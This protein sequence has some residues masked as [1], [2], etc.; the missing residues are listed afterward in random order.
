MLLAA[1][2]TAQDPD[3]VRTPSTMDRVT[4]YQGQALVERVVT[5]EA[6]QPG[7]MSVVV[8]P[9]PLSADASS[10]QTKVESGSLVV[11]GLELRRRAGAALE[12]GQR[13]ALVARLDGLRAERRTVDVESRGIEAGR[14]ALA[15]MMEGIGA[16]G[17][18]A[19]S[20]A[21]RDDKTVRF[22]MEQARMLDKDRAA[23]EVRYEE[24]DRAIADLEAQLEAG[25]QIREDHQEA[26]LSLF[27]ERPGTAT[28]RLSYLVYGAGWQPTYDVRV[29][30]DLTGVRVGLVA[31][32][33]Q[34]TGEDW[35]DAQLL[36]STSTPSVGLDPP[37]LPR[38][39]MGFV[40]RRAE[41]LRG[42]GYVG[43][44]NAPAAATML[45]S[46]SY[47]GADEE[48][49]E[50]FEAAPTVG[51]QDFGLTA[52][53]VLPERKDLPSNGKAHR[54]TIREMPLQV[55]PERYV[56]PSLSD[57]AYLRAEV[58]LSGETPLLPGVAKV[59]LGPDFLGEASMPL[60]RQGDSTTLNLGIDPN[61]VVEYEEVED[62][63]ENPGRFSLS[64][65][66]H[67]VRTYRARLKLS[68]SARGPISVVVEEAVPVSN[69][70]R[71]EITLTDVKPQ[72]ATDDEAKRLFEERGTLRWSLELAPGAGAV[73]EWGYDVA[74]PYKSDP[75]IV[76]QD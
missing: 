62:R 54:F 53:F 65:T 22:F 7:P 1:P 73:V 35:T 18:P 6:A 26:R 33:S 70:D 68:A 16:G 45:D 3:P 46:I 24:I 55:R 38:R 9:M 20:A 34:R 32:V 50:A 67:I 71:I 47:D 13:E 8:G 64:S 36:L 44:S 27:F 52:Q 66:A 51:I 29:A 76:E 63:R 61:L 41:M 11:Q 42:L 59:F 60:L 39:W 56:V 25:A 49:E 30:P 28:L 40:S 21:A 15:A 72:R 5:L 4:V 14:A 75:V 23:L 17:D 10:F 74:F 58:T 69:D 48:E 37:D 57:H 19:A 12:G 31:Q 43:E 2:A